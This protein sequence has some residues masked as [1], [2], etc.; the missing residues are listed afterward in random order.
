M[1]K[2]KSKR[3]MPYQDKWRIS[4]VV[5]VHGGAQNGRGIAILAAAL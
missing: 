2:P 4:D 5:T 3:K 1:T